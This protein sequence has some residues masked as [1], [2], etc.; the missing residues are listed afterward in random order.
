MLSIANLV[1]NGMEQYYVF[2]NAF[3][4]ETIEVLDLYVYYIGFG[5][6]STGGIPLATVISMLKSVISLTLLFSVNGLSKLLR[7]SSIV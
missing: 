6:G 1:N 3:N 4:A 7:G 2:R 5:R